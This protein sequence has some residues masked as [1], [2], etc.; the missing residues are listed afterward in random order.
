MLCGVVVGC[1]RGL[2]WGVVVW[3]LLRVIAVVIVVIV[4]VVILFDAHRHCD[5][6]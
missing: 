3:L 2:L 5:T 1:C 6:K 4:V